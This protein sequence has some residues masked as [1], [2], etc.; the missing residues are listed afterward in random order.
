MSGGPP[1][2][3]TPSAGPTTSGAAGEPQATDASGGRRHGVLR[4]AAGLA[5]LG[6]MLAF[7]GPGRLLEA[8]RGADPRWLAAGL[9]AAVASTLASA[10]RWRAL[11]RWLG[12]RVTRGWAIAVYLRGVAV[13]ALL[14]G[15]VVG[16]DLLRAWSLQRDGCPRGLAGLSVVLDRVSGLWM[17]FACAALGAL[18][19]IGTPQLGLLAGPVGLAAPSGQALAALAVLA[20]TLLLPPPVLLRSPLRRFLERPRAARQYL[21]QAGASVAVQGCAIASLACAARAFGVALPPWLIALTALP[22][23]LLA[24]L[25]VGFGGW[26]TRE[27]A[28]AACWHAFGVPAE[29]AVGA[30]VS[31]GAFALV[32]AGA[33]L[34]CRPPAAPA[35]R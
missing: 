19:G 18:A 5:M 23:F 9:A 30:A 29:L 26:G 3:P 4:L 24:A 12:H 16:G 20:A 1:L 22:I 13:N 21:L 34:L 31:I 28:T 2:P 17:L 35:P 6:A 11:V 7:A 32:Q 27:A 8:A 10:L 25:P 15:A 33:G 14:P